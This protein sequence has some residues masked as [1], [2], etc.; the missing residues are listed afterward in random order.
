VIVSQR[1]CYHLQKGVGSL[2][3]FLSQQYVQVRARGSVVVKARRDI[4]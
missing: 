4:P 3:G 2:M 1:Q